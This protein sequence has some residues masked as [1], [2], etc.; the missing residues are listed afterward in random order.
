MRL[1]IVSDVHCQA[2]ALDRALAAMGAIDRLICLGDAINQFAFCNATVAR[3]H[4][5]DALTVLGNHEETFFSGPGRG[6]VDPDLSAWLASRP[7]RIETAFDGVRTLIVHSTPWLSDHA[8]VP[9][10]HRDFHRF[11]SPDFDLVLYGHTHQPVVARLGGTL[12]VNPGSTGEGR[13]TSDGFIR[14]CAVFDTSVREA[15][16]LDLD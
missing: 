10:T 4:A 9:A 15:A 7:T 5:H 12:V 16:I 6:Q 1:G 11:A 8:Y 3:L 13:P 2:G 14:S